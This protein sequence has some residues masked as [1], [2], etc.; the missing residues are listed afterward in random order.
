[1][2]STAAHRLLATIAL[3]LVLTLTNAQVTTLNVGLLSGEATC[4]S[5][6]TYTNS[7]FTTFPDFP[8]FDLTVNMLKF[9]K[10]KKNWT[11]KCL[12]TATDFNSDSTLHIFLGKSTI[13]D[14]ELTS[15]VRSRI[16]LLQNKLLLISKALRGYNMNLWF[17]IIDI[18]ALLFLLVLFVIAGAYLLSLESKSKAAKKGGEKG[19]SAFWTL[20]C[21]CLKLNIPIVYTNGGRLIVAG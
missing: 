15:T 13:D 21:T 5:G 19:I 4:A 20:M 6:T 18:F 12:S 17:S 2:S 16:P 7:G 11:I 14:T 10:W 3:A 9:S 8:L 1:M